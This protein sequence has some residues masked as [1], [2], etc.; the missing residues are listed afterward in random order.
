VVAPNVVAEDGT[1]LSLPRRRLL[2]SSSGSSL[3]T[4][5]PN[6]TDAFGSV[7]EAEADGA[8]KL[9][10]AAVGGSAFVRG[11]GVPPKLK[12][13]EEF[14]AVP[15]LLPNE[16]TGLLADSAFSSELLLLEVGNFKLPP[17]V[18]GE[19]LSAGSVTGIGRLGFLGE[20]VVE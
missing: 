1:S 18:G 8:P 16:K 11:A 14:V 4:I 2:R 15:A 20:L 12:P 13:V 19:V 7:E 10:V 17:F 3:F 6:G 5:L 9:K